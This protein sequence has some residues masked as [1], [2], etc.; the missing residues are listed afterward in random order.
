MAPRYLPLE[1]PG[2]QVCA[3]LRRAAGHGARMV[4]VC[5]GAFALAAAGLLDHRRAVTHWQYAGQL[6]ARHPAVKVDP[7]VLPLTCASTWPATPAPPPPPTGLRTRAGRPRPAG[8]DP[9]Q[10]RPACH[11][12]P[13]RPAPEHGLVHGGAIGWLVPG[14]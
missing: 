11:W 6:A 14:A 10:T 13:P 9:E 4:S 3:A 1:D 7:D 2:E 8:Q 5:T 12:P